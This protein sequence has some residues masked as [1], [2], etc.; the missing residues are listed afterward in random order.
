[1][2]IEELGVAHQAPILDCRK[3]ASA[4]LQHAFEVSSLR[5]D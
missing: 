1:M 2:A 4:T 5:F 3:I